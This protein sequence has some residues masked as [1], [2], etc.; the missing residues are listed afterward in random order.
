MPF[1][2]DIKIPPI[3][4]FDFT[5]GGAFHFLFQSWMLPVRRI[6][7]RLPE[8]YLQSPEQPPEQPPEEESQLLKLADR[9]FNSLLLLA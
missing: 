3:I 5:I 8:D 9:F 2:S 4:K 6:V 1:L 7:Y